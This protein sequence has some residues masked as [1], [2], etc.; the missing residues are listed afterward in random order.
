MIYLRLYIGV[1]LEKYSKYLTGFEFTLC[2]IGLGLE[3]HL[4]YVTGLGLIFI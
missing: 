3:K 1:G 4:F 2:Y